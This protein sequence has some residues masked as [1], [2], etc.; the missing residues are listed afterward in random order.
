VAWHYRATTLPWAEWLFQRSMRSMTV[1]SLEAFGR[2]LLHR[3]DRLPQ[4]WA[5]R[6][7]QIWATDGA[8]PAFFGTVRAGMTL[9]GQR[10][11]HTQR[12][13]EMHHPALIV[14]GR[15]DPV[16]PVR[17]GIRAA[18]RMPSARLHIFEECGHMPIWEC[19]E[20]FGELVEGFLEE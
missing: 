16:I 20:E 7:Q 14:W 13:H 19:P 4:G 2:S 3:R 10:V 15:Q 18:Q 11:D 9:A 1:Q 6:R 5:E 8:V 12:L 17:H